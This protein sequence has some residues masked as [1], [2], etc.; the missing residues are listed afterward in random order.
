MDVVRLGARADRVRREALEEDESGDDE[1]AE[2][3]QTPVR[4]WTPDAAPAGRAQGFFP[5]PSFLP[6][7]VVVVAVVV[8][9]VVC[10]TWP[11]AAADLPRVV[12]VVVVTVVFVCPGATPER[13]GSNA[14][15]V[16]TV[17]VLVWPGA[18]FDLPCVPE[19][20]VAVADGGTG[21]GRAG[22]RSAGVGA[23]AFGM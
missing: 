1:Q 3:E 15:V 20:V 18:T 7:T 8:V 14:V 22:T 5:C 13:P 4:G 19:G 6:G 2:A 9:V 11:G 21:A 16:F 12:V 23:T 10:L 17:T